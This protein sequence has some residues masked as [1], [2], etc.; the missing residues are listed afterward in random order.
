[1]LGA[2][3]RNSL[4]VPLGHGVDDYNLVS[5]AWETISKTHG[6]NKEEVMNLH[7]LLLRGEKTNFIQKG[8]QKNVDTYRLFLPKKKWGPKALFIL[9]WPKKWGGGTPGPLGDDIPD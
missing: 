3:A 8:T 5:E 7:T 1:M 2:V 9:N 6:K 4:G